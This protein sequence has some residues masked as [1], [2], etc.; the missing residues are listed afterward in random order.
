MAE[1]SA[2]QWR[3]LSPLL[4]ELLEAQS[5][6]RAQRLEQ[7]RRDDAALALQLE[8]LLA[9]R[10]HA[11]REG[12]LE[13]GAFSMAQE[14]S[15]AG[16]AIG[17]YTLQEAI[18]YGGMGTVWRAERSDGRYQATVAVKFLNLA[19]LERGGVERFAREGNLLARLSHPNIARLL[20]AGVTAGNQPYLVL[21]FID[22]VPIDVWCDQ[23]SLTIEARLRLFLDVLAAVAHAH[24]NLI[25]H[26]DLKPS[27]ILITPSG[28]VKLLDFGIGKLIEDQSG[29]ASPT[30][31]TQLAG[32]AF[33]PDFAAPEQVAQGDVTTATDVYA[34]GVLLYMLLAGRHPTA[35]PTATQVDRLRA[36]VE[37]EPPRLSDAVS[38][39]SEGES[40]P[41]ARSRAT[42]P[43][44]L[45]RALRG[46]LDNI[47]AKSLKKKPAE[48][49]ANATALADDVGRFL[50]HQPITAR[51]DTVTYRVGKFV[52]RY[53]LAV[54]AA[55][56]IVLVLVAGVVGTAW[57][58]LEAK[59]QEAAALQQRDRA[60]ALLGRN[61]AIIDFIDM[62]FTE[63]LPPGQAVVIQQMLERGEALI[64]NAF[65]D[66]PAQQADLL[67]VLASYYTSLNLPKKPDLLF[68]RARSLIAKIDDPSLKAELACSHASALATLGRGE[69]ARQLLDEW[70]NAPNVAANVAVGCLQARA[71]L[72]QNVADSKAA[73]HFAEAALEKLRESNNPSAKLEAALLGDVGFAYH[74]AGR[75]VEAD[76]HYQLALERMRALGRQE[77]TLARRML[78]DWGLVRYG[79]GDFKRG[80][81]IFDE[82]IQLAQKVQ[83]NEPI[84]PSILGNRAF[85]LEQLGRYK[86]ALAAYERTFDAGERTGFVAAKAY[87]LAGSANVFAALGDPTEA[88]R[89]LDRATPL[90]G[91]LAEAH[92]ARIRH[93]MVQARV[94]AA[95]GE[96]NAASK[97]FTGVIEL[98]SKQGLSHPALASAYRQR[99]E[100]ALKLGDREQ[101]L[102]DAER[103][104]E[105]ARNL[106]GDLP[107]SDLTGLA[108]LTL[109]RVFRANGD[110]QRS[111]EALQMAEVHLINTVGID[112]PDARAAQRLLAGG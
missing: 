20:D 55:A 34:L 77:S 36:I 16:Q 71:I 15:L 19:L 58:A 111:R 65:A 60:L 87:S 62:L 112:N 96:L 81:E 7:I 17:A 22:G 61:E 9:Q 46:D 70:T 72:A 53:R 40:A 25:L 102:T 64:D 109:A 28:E 47:V 101:A 11:T 45:A 14:P 5:E 68:A 30:E 108:W 4:D 2:T 27:N 76:R 78:L 97:R 23:R 43:S 32:R 3:E 74:L 99:A 75:N 37:S 51:P 39:A 42:T 92:P 41:L 86:E 29:A 57:Q 67:R 73:L 48:R 107:H 63:A 8:E 110:A 84:P 33:T 6:T 89:S 79:M 10:T 26:R 106:Q 52:R 18:G 21:E 104:L 98:M 1:I 82:S 103:A 80:L 59:R 35:Q 44:K 38:R 83:G 85:G 105:L 94:E 95:R 49:Y 66:R 56:T 50:D 90:I 91:G 31:L 12:F 88:Q 24:S 93:T 13:G 54:G 69:E 100:L